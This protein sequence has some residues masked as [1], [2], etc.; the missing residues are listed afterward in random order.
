M[1]GVWVLPK[2]KAEQGQLE[3]SVA[4]LALFTARPQVAWRSVAKADVTSELAGSSV[5]PASYCSYALHADA[6]PRAQIADGITV[7]RQRANSYLRHGAD[8]TL[9]HV[10]GGMYGTQVRETREL[11]L[12]LAN[13][14]GVWKL[15]TALEDMCMKHEAPEAYAE[16]RTALRALSGGDAQAAI[17]A[18]VADADAVARAAGVTPLDVAGR[19][20]NVAGVWKKVRAVHHT[21]ALDAPTVDPPNPSRRLVHSPTHSPLSRRA[22]AYS[23]FRPPRL[24]LHGPRPS[25]GNS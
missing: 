20:K 10:C 11:L 24:R 19:E 9:G 12:P 15:K 1:L 8:V 23:P 17:R 13:R 22:V 16:V 7:V 2:R 18:A 14:L 6:G 3:V 5:L 25:T 4:I 21:C